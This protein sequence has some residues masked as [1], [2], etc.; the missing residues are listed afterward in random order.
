MLA[1][2]GHG[3]EVLDLNIALREINIYNLGVPLFNVVFWENDY[4]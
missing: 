1:E 4:R 2:I 3:I